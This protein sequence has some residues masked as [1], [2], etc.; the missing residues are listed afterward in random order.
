MVGRSNRTQKQL[1]P[2]TVSSKSQKVQNSWW[3]ST[4][5]AYA[6]ILVSIGAGALINY[7]S[8]AIGMPICIILILVGFWL[9]IR[10]YLKEQPN[11]KV[12]KSATIGLVCLVGITILGAVLFQIN[13]IRTII[14]PMFARIPN[15][16]LNNVSTA[17][18]STISDVSRIQTFVDASS[19]NPSENVTLTVGNWDIPFKW[20]DFARGPAHFNLTND[21]TFMLYKD[22]GRI[23]V[24][25]SLYGGQN[26]APVEMHGRA[27]IVKPQNW[28]KNYDDNIFE[29]VNQDGAPVFQVIYES[30]FHVIVY[31][32]FPSPN[33]SVIWVTQSGVNFN[34]SPFQTF[35]LDPIFKYPSSKYQGQ[36]RG[37]WGTSV[38]SHEVK[39]P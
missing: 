13:T 34:P 15:S 4:S 35:H 17:N 25:T 24:D 7:F 31:G 37:S 23:Y 3:N 14:V 33:G 38:D 19:I 8:P 5:A 1:Q 12:M 29:V 26:F 36:R 22:N 11:P 10:A 21:V 32:I 6:F 30:Q 27:F 16:S 18:S 20:S 9:L 2:Q 28:D 39:L